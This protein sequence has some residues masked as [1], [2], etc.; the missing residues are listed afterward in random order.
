MHIPFV[1]LLMCANLSVH[2]RVR[3]RVRDVSVSVS[4]SWFAACVF[5]CLACS[6][7]YH[8]WPHR[9]TAVA[10]LVAFSCVCMMHFLVARVASHLHRSFSF[11]IA[12]IFAQHCTPLP[13]SVC[14][15]A[16]L[17]RIVAHWTGY[18]FLTAD[19]CLHCC[20]SGQVSMAADFAARDPNSCAL[21]FR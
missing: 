12:M 6:F 7:D 3:V 14:I 1:S 2:V 19:F 9:S 15:V 11:Q 5:H 17:G 10:R 4:C 20:P 8:V 18:K 21:K 16:R 13:T